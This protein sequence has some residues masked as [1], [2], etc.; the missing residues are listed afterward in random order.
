MRKPSENDY[1]I[2]SFVV[3]QIEEWGMSYGDAVRAVAT[4]CDLTIKGVYGMS[5]RVRAWER[6]A[7]T[8][9]FEPLTVPELQNAAK[10]PYP[11]NTSTL[12]DGEGNV[13]A[14]WVKTGP[15]RTNAA[16]LVKDMLEHVKTIKP[17]E[18]SK[19]QKPYMQQDTLTVIPLADMHIGLY[20]A[21]Q[22]Q[23]L[24]ETLEQYK[25]AFMELIDAVPMSNVLLA[26][27]GDF[28]HID[29]YSNVTPRQRNTLEVQADYGKIVD[30]A[31]ELVCFM[32]SELDYH[33][34]GDVELL[35]LAGNHDE[36]TG[37]VMRTALKHLYA[38][39]EF[40]NILPVEGRFSY[41]LWGKTLLG[42]THGDTVKSADLPLLM[43]TDQPELWGAANNRVWHT[44]HRHHKLIEEFSGCTVEIHRAPCPKDMWHFDRGYRA[45]KGLACVTYDAKQG[46][47]SRYQVNL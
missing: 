42:F 26:N 8:Q 32:V 16:D 9:E 25:R 43:A 46:E 7:T 37:V 29:D 24:D 34:T 12:V 22:S 44:G 33:V 1:L 13:K 27:L 20:S 47:L 38:K 19:R 35:W 5:G 15:E 21:Y 3:D 17:F 45:Q 6:L 31:F 36:S 23:T 30:A 39:H 41:Y 18:R 11:P 28:T 4:N 14:Q 2:H 10:Q 40:V